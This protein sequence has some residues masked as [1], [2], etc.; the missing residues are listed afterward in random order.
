MNLKLNQLGLGPTTEDKVLSCC[1][2]V[3]EFQQNFE[4]LFTACDLVGHLKMTAT[5]NLEYLGPE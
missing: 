4:E 2:W 5:E 1:G 3:E